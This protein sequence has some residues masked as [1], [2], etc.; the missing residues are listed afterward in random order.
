[1][2]EGRI[3]WK[4]RIHVIYHNPQIHTPAR[5]LSDDPRRWCTVRLGEQ[6]HQ[7]QLPVKRDSW[8][9]TF[10]FL[11]YNLQDDTVSHGDVMMMSS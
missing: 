8:H 1:M 5:A 7:L 10:S 9:A 3:W 2:K 4:L 6:K 11:V